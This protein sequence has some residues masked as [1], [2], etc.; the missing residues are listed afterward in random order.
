MPEK[1]DAHAPQNL[2][3]DQRQHGCPFCDEGMA[4]RA[5]HVHGTCLAVADRHPVAPGHMLIIPRRH[6]VD[7]FG[8]TEQERRDAD[9]LLHLLRAHITAVDPTVTGFNIGVNCG[10]DAGQT[11]LHTHPSHPAPPGR[12]PGPARRRARRH[13]R[14]HGLSGRLTRRR[15]HAAP[16]Q[17]VCPC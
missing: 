8:L 14:S 11:I 10:A 17:A 3:D 2:Q 6:V 15:P 16:R 1:A 5:P 12:L 7:W 9:A 4:A 13:S